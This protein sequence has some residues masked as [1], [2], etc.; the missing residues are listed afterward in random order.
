MRA[1]FSS[2]Q[3]PPTPVLKP[4]DI[5]ASQTHTNADYAA[6]SLSV[7]PT[8][9]RSLASAKPQFVSIRA[10]QGP[11]DPQAVEALQK[12]TKATRDSRPEVSPEKVSVTQ[13]SSTLV[14][15]RIR[16][17]EAS[18][19]PEGSVPAPPALTNNVEPNQ[20]Q[21]G[22][23]Q[24]QSTYQSVD[25]VPSSNDRIQ[26]H[27]TKP[28]VT[29]PLPS[30]VYKA[31]SDGNNRSELTPK[32]ALSQYTNVP[33]SSR[34]A[35]SRTVRF[36]LPSPPDSPEPTD[37]VPT[38]MEQI[39]VT[40]SNHLRPVEGSAK[41]LRS[42]PPPV[43]LVPSSSSGSREALTPPSPE[44]PKLSSS[45]HTKDRSPLQ[46]HKV[47]EQRSS[48]IPSHTPLATLHPPGFSSEPSS[49]PYT[50]PQASPA[51][52]G[53]SQMENSESTGR[54]T[55]TAAAP[56]TA[57]SSQSQPLSAATRQANVSQS[58]PSQSTSRSTKASDTLPADRVPRQGHTQ[59]NI[60]SQ[61]SERHFTSHNYFVSDPLALATDIANAAETI[62]SNIISK[63]STIEP[64]PHSQI[65]ASGRD[66]RSSKKKRSAQPQTAADEAALDVSRPAGRSKKDVYDPSV[67]ERQTE[68]RAYPDELFAA[69][70]APHA[71]VATKLQDTTLTVSQNEITPASHGHAHEK[72]L[73]QSSSDNPMHKSVEGRVGR[74]KAHFYTH[75]PQPSFEEFA[76]LNND[77]N[78]VPIPVPLRKPTSSSQA[79]IRDDLAGTDKQ[80][81]PP[82]R[83]ANAIHSTVNPTSNADAS[84]P[85]AIHSSRLQDPVTFEVSILEKLVFVYVG[86]ILNMTVG[87]TA[88]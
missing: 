25:T 83:Q 57:A 86:L 56:P 9:N 75:A 74:Q 44:P 54:T 46:S 6:P 55:V 1:K 30:R 29:A 20:S 16:K 81:M 53:P 35:T 50:A 23:A 52:S 41:E 59:P 22:S 28:E 61:Q 42:P 8:V 76:P 38:P 10:G 77:S 2:A 13:S 84:H 65:R 48:V 80:D 64:A 37:V 82:S 40:T 85:P 62:L 18:I 43:P 68:A 87:T 49:S 73:Y 5:G 58:T 31:K 19:R 26:I 36:D 66:G 72:S 78:D 69:R 7:L 39:S 60:I 79:I 24:Q 67:L 4:S 32:P 21:A 70:T 47:T 3:P 17:Y 27:E 33:A 11:S 51:R 63:P 12:S 34:P 14:R 15:D 88:D 45:L 71:A